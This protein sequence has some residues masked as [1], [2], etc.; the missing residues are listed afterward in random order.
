MKEEALNTESLEKELDEVEKRL[1]EVEELIEEVEKE[2]EPW[3]EEY[4]EGP[5]CEDDYEGDLR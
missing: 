1:E 2:L 3:E 5:C 4:E